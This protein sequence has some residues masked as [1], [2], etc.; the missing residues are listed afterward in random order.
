MNCLAVSKGYWPI[1]YDA[2]T[3]S[4]P[5]IFK[6]IFDEYAHKYSTKKAMRKIE[7]HF[8][9]GHA[10]IT[11]TFNNGE[12]NF[13]CMPIHAMLITYFDESKITNKE[14]GVSSM[15]LST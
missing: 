8:N 4:I 10:N 11:L 9:L 7:Y 5:P 6:N 12:F 13:K 1:N 15:E 3:F 14:M 2:P